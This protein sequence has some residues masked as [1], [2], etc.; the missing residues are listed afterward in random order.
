MSKGG[1]PP[2]Q[3]F[4]WVN[5]HLVALPLHSGLSNHVLGTV[6]E[7]LIS[8]RFLS[9]STNP[10]LCHLSSVPR[11]PLVSRPGD[12][13]HRRYLCGAGVWPAGGHLHGR[14]G[15]CVDVEADTRN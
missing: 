1:G 5:S 11:A 13:E 7:F 8:S 3:R 4:V 9:V 2:C 12:G 10:S 15:V 14:A 6:L